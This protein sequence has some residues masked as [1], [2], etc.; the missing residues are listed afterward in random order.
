MEWLP[1]SRKTVSISVNTSILDG[2][3]FNIIVNIMEWLYRNAGKL[4]IFLSIRQYLTR[5]RSILLSMPLCLTILLSVC[6]LLTDIATI[7]ELVC[8]YIF[9]GRLKREINSF[10]PIFSTFLSSY[11]FW[12][13]VHLVQHRCFFYGRPLSTSYELRIEPM[14]LSRLLESVPVKTPGRK[15][16]W[17]RISRPKEKNR[18]KNTQNKHW[19]FHIFTIKLIIRFNF[20]FYILKIRLYCTHAGTAHN[21]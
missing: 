4:S 11:L 7:I 13:V 12:K 5:T 6:G 2:H 15:E 9:K 18:R 3:T 19:Q 17:R 14:S 20:N 1:E 10:I 8:Y 21:Y 16:A